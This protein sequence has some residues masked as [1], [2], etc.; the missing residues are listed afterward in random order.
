MVGIGLKRIAEQVKGDDN[1]IDDTRFWGVDERRETS[2]D[3]W[4]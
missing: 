1:M 4:M 3:T 2:S